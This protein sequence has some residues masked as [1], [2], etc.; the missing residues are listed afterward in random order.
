M[1]VLKPKK[2]VLSVLL[3]LSVIFALGCQSTRV[4]IDSL[5]I[6]SHPVIPKEKDL[7]DLFEKY[8]Y[9]MIQIDDVNEIYFN[10]CGR[11]E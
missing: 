9:L 5:C 8:E 1:K 2:I 10:K 7:D 4:K 11:P 6:D 3:I